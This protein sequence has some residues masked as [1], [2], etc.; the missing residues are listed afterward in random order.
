MWT[1]N[2]KD[3]KHDVRMADM[4]TGKDVWMGDVKSGVH[5]AW[6]GDVK[7][8]MHDVARRV[9]ARRGD[10]ESQGSAMHDL[11][12]RGNVKNDVQDRQIGDVNNGKDM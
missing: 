2:V 1:G 10:G 7:S 3:G 9:L 5:D 4:K 12:R 8:C 11:R 6:I